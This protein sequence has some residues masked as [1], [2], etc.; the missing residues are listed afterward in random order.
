MNQNDSEL[1]DRFLTNELS[2]AAFDQLMER[3]RHEPTLIRKLLALSTNEELIGEWASRPHEPTVELDLPG[4]Q[5]T[6]PGRLLPRKPARG[7]FRQAAYL[8]VSAAA[9]VIC[10]LGLWWLS[11]P[12]MIAQIQSTSN[13]VG[14]DQS[15]DWQTVRP[16]ETLEFASGIIELKTIK[17]VSLVLEGPIHCQF[18]SAEQ[19]VLHEGR[20]YADVPV[21][22][23]G[24]TIITPDG[25]VIDWGTKFGVEVIPE[26]K[27][28]VHVFQGRVTAELVSGTKEQLADITAGHAIA[29]SRESKQIETLKLSNKFARKAALP[30]EEFSFRGN[31]S[32]QS[33]WFDSGL[34]PKPIHT[35]SNKN[36]HYPGLAPTEKGM[37]EI[38]G[39]NQ[40]SWSP[41][42]RRWQNGYL[43]MLVYPDDDFVKRLGKQTATLLSFGPVDEPD[44]REIRLLVRKP[45]QFSRQTAEFGMEVNGQQK[46]FEQPLFQGFKPCLVVI[47]LGKNDIDLWINPARDSFG[48]DQPPPPSI[49]L[50][51]TSRPESRTLWINDVH[52]PN[53]TWFWIDSIR[54]GDRWADVAPRP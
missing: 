54:G 34:S 18:V 9:L 53:C 49:T 48:S 17:Q 16:G 21:T 7:W 13:V 51:N 19:I 25:E 14:L 50:P 41:V 6:R 4:S 10:A 11:L 46:Y 20:L 39:G 24:L 31:L 47:C 35:V 15:F 42:G 26:K 36:V 29:L 28:E 8:A 30:V 27:T 23:R 1:L 32:E 2:S 45:D 12:A 37:L 52:N 40:A 38:K 33:G 22:G 44:Q 5:Y 43:S 3:L